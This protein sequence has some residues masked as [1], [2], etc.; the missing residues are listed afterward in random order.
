MEQILIRPAFCGTTTCNRILPH[1]KGMGRLAQPSIWNG[2]P[3]LIDE[4]ASYLHNDTI[5]LQWMALT[6]RVFTA[7]AQKMLFEELLILSDKSAY[8]W[9][10]RMLQFSFSHGHEA[11]PFCFRH[12]KKVSLSLGMY[13]SQQNYVILFMDRIKEKL[14]GIEAVCIYGYD[15]LLYPSPT[16]RWFCDFVT[17]TGPSRLAFKGLL[18]PPNILD[19]D[20]PT[21]RTIEFDKCRVYYLAE[22]LKPKGE[23]LSTINAN[24]VLRPS[25]KKWE[26]VGQFTSSKLNQ[27]TLRFLEEAVDLESLNLRGKLPIAL[28]LCF[29]YSINK[30][31]LSLR[32]K[33]RS[34]SNYQ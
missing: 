1:R 6:A 34:T 22:D 11:T 4:I 32:L 26:R 25:G 23:R 18:V 2:L 9:D 24:L 19:F 28:N 5:S 30:Q 27:E 10:M 14:T 29:T 16:C 7:P 33:H 3:H 31:S 17:T 15:A 8:I 12:V 21:V 20:F 13:Q